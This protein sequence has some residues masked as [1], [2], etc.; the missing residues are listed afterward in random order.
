MIV[1]LFSIALTYVILHNNIEK[2]KENIKNIK[3]SF[4]NEQKDIVKKEL[5][6]LKVQICGTCKTQKGYIQLEN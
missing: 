4:I 2:H 6:S 3:E 1:V 5:Q